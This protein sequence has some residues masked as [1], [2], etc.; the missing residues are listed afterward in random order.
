MESRKHLTDLHA[1]H[2]EWI[3]AL[4]FYKDDLSALNN[5]LQELVVNNSKVEILAQIEH[6]QNQFIRQSEVI[7]I[8][9]HDIKAEE[10]NIV[11]NIQ[12][13]PTASDHRSAPDHSELRDRYQTFE[14]LF[15]E[16]REEFN[17]FAS[18]T[19]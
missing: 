17:T 15:K 8:L 10:N 2:N 13:N 9:V 12:A 18:R 19:F 6:F 11:K 1:E 7:D 3:N 5:R 16:L 14:K 4:K